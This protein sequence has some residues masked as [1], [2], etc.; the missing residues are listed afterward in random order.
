MEQEHGDGLNNIFIFI[1]HPIIRRLENTTQLRGFLVILHCLCDVVRRFSIADFV[2]H[3]LAT[4]DIAET[5]E[6]DLASLISARLCIASIPV[7][8]WWSLL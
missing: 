2:I 5:A 8:E 6:V 4:R 3:Q 7:P 1:L